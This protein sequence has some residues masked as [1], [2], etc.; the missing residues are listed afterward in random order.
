MTT[1]RTSPARSG[2]RKNQEAL[3][4][5]FFRALNDLGIA[6]AVPAASVRITRD[7]FSITGLT[8]GQLALLTNALED[9]VESPAPFA[10]PAPLLEGGL[11]QPER[12]PVSF[13]AARIV[14]QLV[15]S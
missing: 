1:H 13:T 10:D 15:N 14:S 8:V 12:L 11:T 4:R 9:A 5:R 3:L 2:N 7:G 6:D